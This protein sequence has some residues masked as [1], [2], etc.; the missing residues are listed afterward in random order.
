MSTYFLQNLFTAILPFQEQPDAVKSQR[1]LE[2]TKRQENYKWGGQ[3]V[4]KH[5]PGYLEAVTHADIPRDSQFSDE[6]RS[7]VDEDKKKAIVK[8]GLSYLTSLFDSWDNFDD[9]QKILDRAYGGIPKIVED[10]R[11][12]TDKVFGSMFLNGCNPN[13]IQRCEK[14]PSNF[15]VTEEMVKSFLDRGQTLQEEIKVRFSLQLVRKV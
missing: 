13:V 6:A 8:L 5:L 3:E 1:I 9:F 11:W 2:V 15:P 14:L 12:K 10:D 7:S 4:Y